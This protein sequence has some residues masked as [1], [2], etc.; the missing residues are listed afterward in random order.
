MGI[1]TYINMCI[2]MC[3]DMCRDMC[4]DMCR[5]MRVTRWA[6]PEIVE[7]FCHAYAIHMLIHM[8]QGLE[9]GWDG[10][11]GLGDGRCCLSCFN[12]L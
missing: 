12:D 9:D 4:I 8:P 2:G 11:Q 5:D 10:P 7:F 1:D 3:I 6:V